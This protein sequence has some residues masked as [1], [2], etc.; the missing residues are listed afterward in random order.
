MIRCPTTIGSA[1]IGAAPVIRTSIVACRFTTVTISPLG[2]TLDR[3][4]LATQLLAI[5]SARGGHCVARY[6]AGPAQ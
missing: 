2:E 1:G 6:L 3:S 5:C 4:G